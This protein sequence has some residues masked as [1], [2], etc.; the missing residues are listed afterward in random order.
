MLRSRQTHFCVKCSNLPVRWGGHVHRGGD[1]EKVIAG[2]CEEHHER[3]RVGSTI[4]LPAIAEAFPNRVALHRELTVTA[5]EGCEGCYG[6]VP[7][8][9]VVEDDYKPQTTNYKLPMSPEEMTKR[10]TEMMKLIPI[11]KCCPEARKYPTV[12]FTVDF[13]GGDSHR[14]KGHWYIRV[15]RELVLVWNPNFQGE[16]AVPKYCP[17]CGKALPKMQRKIPVPATVCRV[18]D[19]GYYCATCHQRLQACL[20]D[21][22]GSAFEPVIRLVPSPDKEG[23]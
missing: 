17:Y 22:L 9:T 3:M 1:P 16:I 8:D 11:P 21:P 4:V 20:C 12:A 6:D 7:S 15:I 10:R 19:G 13:D 14:A 2:W 5:H 18:K 23:A